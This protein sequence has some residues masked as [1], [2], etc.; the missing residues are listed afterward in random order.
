MQ[1][2]LTDVNSD[3]PTAPSELDST[4]SRK[5]QKTRHG[6]LSVTEAEW[7][8]F[9]KDVRDFE[10]QH[11]RNSGKFAFQFVEGPLVKAIRSGSW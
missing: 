6:G 2:T 8:L 5:R 9:E 4:D 11:V 3:Q 7:R 1:A 10:V